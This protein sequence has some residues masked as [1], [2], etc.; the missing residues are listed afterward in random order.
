MSF[1]DYQ[2][3]LLQNLYNDASL[4]LATGYKLYDHLKINCETGYQLSKINQFLK[5]IEVNQVLTK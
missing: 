4:D 2:I 1:N 3:Q 5:S